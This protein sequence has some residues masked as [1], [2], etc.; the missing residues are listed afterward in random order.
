MSRFTRE[1]KSQMALDMASNYQRK[2]AMLH[3]R[4]G[5]FMAI[6]DLESASDCQHWRAHYARMARSWMGV[7]A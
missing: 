4:V 2:A 5:E 3:K 7:D 6:G 1:Q